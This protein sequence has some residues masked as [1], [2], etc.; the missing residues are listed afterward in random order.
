MMNNIDPLET[1]RLV[2]DHHAKKAYFMR[3]RLSEKD[4]E[5]QIALTMNKPAIFGCRCGKTDNFRFIVDDDP[6]TSLAVIQCAACQVCSPPFEMRKPQMRDE[7]AKRMGAEIP[8]LDAPAGLD[9]ELPGDLSDDPANQW[10]R[11]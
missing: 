10:W 7:I 6:K 9:I 5:R 8:D 3:P 4:A 11:E 2:W 1:L